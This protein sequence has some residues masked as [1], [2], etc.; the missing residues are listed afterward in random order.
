MTKL[1][2]P[3]FSLLLV[4]LF[5]T[6]CKGQTKT[7]KAQK[8]VVDQLSFAS[9]K[10]KLTKTQ[11]ANKYQNVHCIIQ[12][13]N[14]NLWFGTTG[15]D[16][17]RYDGKEFTQFT[18]K[19]G[20]SNNSV[21]SILEDK[22]GKIWFGTDDGVSRYD[23]GTITKIPF[24]IPSSIGVGTAISQ[25][26]KTIV[27][28]IFQDKKGIIWFGLNA[29]IYCYN[30]KTFSYFLD[31]PNIVNKSN[32]TLKSIQCMVE[33]TKGNLWLGS[34]PQA[35]EGICLFAGKSL[36]NFKP[37][38]EGWIRK[39]NEAKNGTVL[40]DTRHIGLVAYNGRTFSGFSEPRNLRKELLTTILVDSKENIWY[41]SDFTL[42][43]M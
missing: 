16:V 23:G 19:D 8:T 35:S 18:S 13:R 3:I 26:G 12:D 6:S 17:Y 40:F 9:K 28:S 36:T 25:A 2:K 22:S 20:L 31:N 5:F 11:G 29:G 32:L 24:N 41:G 7:K 33:D 42:A 1:K 37:K 30:S 4:S 38:D 27:W 34:G 43:M 15:E 14:D 10:K 39:I 21:W